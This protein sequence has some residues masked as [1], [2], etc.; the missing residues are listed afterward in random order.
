MLGEEGIFCHDYFEKPVFI[1]WYLLSL[2]ER[3][4]DIECVGV[5]VN[6]HMNGKKVT[7]SSALTVTDSMRVELPVLQRRSGQLA[8][9]LLHMAWQQPLL[10]N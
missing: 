2:R 1:P 5:N 10:R 9:I 4:V 7:L 8:Q 3:P 6:L